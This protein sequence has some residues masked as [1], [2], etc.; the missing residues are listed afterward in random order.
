M[1]SETTTNKT[2]ANSDTDTTNTGSLD[3]VVKSEYILS[4]RPSCLAA[5]PPVE[6]RTKPS[7]VSNNDNRDNNNNDERDNNNNDSKRSKKNKGQNKK[8]PRDNR[9]AFGDK[10]CLAIVR[11]QPCP[12]LNT[13]KGCRYNHNLKE[14][15]ANRPID[16]RDGEGGAAW[17]KGGCPFWNMKG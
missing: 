8:R 1:S 4:E 9:I 13:P 11:G 2:T 12:F 15:L 10:V 7:G 3:L 16:I 6:E 17:L 5:P 14:I